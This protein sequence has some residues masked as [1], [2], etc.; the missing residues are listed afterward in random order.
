MNIFG[1]FNSS[2]QRDVNTQIDHADGSEQINQ[3]RAMGKMLT[4]A[5][6]RYPHSSMTKR[7]DFRQ[8]LCN[9]FAI[10]IL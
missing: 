5:K 9:A 3:N 1:P 7:M 10:P 8:P 4:S 6:F 2:G